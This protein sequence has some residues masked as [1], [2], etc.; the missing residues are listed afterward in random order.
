MHFSARA[1]FVVSLLLL[2]FCLFRTPAYAQTV[3]QPTTPVAQTVSNGYDFHTPDAY[4]NVPRNHHSY[5]QIVVIDVFSAFMCQLT[6]IDPTNPHQP[7]LGV[8]TSTGKIGMA[9]NSNS[10]SFGQS[11]NPQLGGALGV[12]TTY[13]SALYVPAVGSS[14]YLNYL[15]S[16]FG[17]VKPAYA[18]G[19]Q[20]NCSASPLGYGFCGLQPI[21]ALWTTVRD[22]AYAVLTILFIIVGV[23]VMVRF[24]VDPRTVMTLQNQ[25]PRIII[26][27]LLITFS[28]AIAG[29]MID[30]M[31]TTTYVGINF[32]SNAAPNSKVVI[33]CPNDIR[34]FSQAAEQ[35]LLDQPVSFANTIFQGDC[36]GGILSFGQGGI[37]TVS[38]KVSKSFGGLIQEVVA[39]LLGIKTGGC[40]WTNLSIT[41]C[42]GGYFLFI[43]G[44]IVKLI[45]IV[46]LLIALFRLWFELIKNYVTFLIFV[47]MAPVWIVFGLIPGRPLGFEKWLR[48]IFA[49]LAAFPLVVFILLFARF[50]MDAVGSTT[51]A[52][53]ASN[54]ATHLLSAQNVLGAQTS[55][56]AAQ[57]NAQNVFIPPL[58]GN[59]NI[60]DFSTF[61]AFGAIMIAP[62][63]PGMI[64]ERMKAKGQGDYGKTVAAGLGFAAGAATS[65]GKKIWESANRKDQMGNPEGSI[66]IA[67]QRLGQNLPIIGRYTKW[68]N[69]SIGKAAQRRK[70]M[71]GEIDPKPKP[72]TS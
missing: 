46:A 45:I 36:N 52:S 70:E 38:D 69:E 34:P 35:R 22:A 25:I 56:L 19:A 49:N 59:P 23:G 43:T 15:S 5:T 65:P 33:K 67:K 14:Q 58:V 62:T 12:M 39:Q 2:V 16:N 71:R 42:V 60:A 61:M 37:F 26:A 53:A 68:R 40:S 57:T 31:W 9:S 41:D 11:Q 63:I 66:A 64:K 18:A 30:L 29:L 1:L 4:P 44:L 48:I 32:I 51:V 50:L 28:Y 21:F 72:K 7:C 8:D 47:I 6:G 3:D 27:I 24:R 13:I 55:V 10:Q 20:Q 17:I 54:G